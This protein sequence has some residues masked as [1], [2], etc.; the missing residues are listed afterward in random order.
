MEKLVLALV[1]T[2]KRL[3]RYFQA[4]PIAVITDQP[5]K[6][7]ISLPDVAGRLQKFPRGKNGMSPVDTSVK[8]D[9]KGGEVHQGKEVAAVVGKKNRMDDHHSCN[10]PEGEFFQMIARM[11]LIS[12]KS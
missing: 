6:Q 8:G 12:I 9:P 4:H 5:I 3:Q 10:L 1:F 2:A 7:I 11:K